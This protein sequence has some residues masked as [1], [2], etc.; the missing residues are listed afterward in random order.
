[1]ALGELLRLLERLIVNT[2]S[3]KIPVR[4]EKGKYMGNGN[5]KKNIYKNK[6]TME[7]LNTCSYLSTFIVTKQLYIYIYNAYGDRTGL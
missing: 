1:M 3:N 7:T 6:N 4:T 2:L 5:I